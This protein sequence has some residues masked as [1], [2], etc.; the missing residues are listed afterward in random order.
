MLSDIK[1]WRNHYGERSEREV[2][3]GKKQQNKFV[4]KVKR[5][6]AVIIPLRGT[7]TAIILLDRKLMIKSNR[8]Y[9]RK[10]HKM[11]I[12]NQVLKT[13]I[14]GTFFFVVKSISTK[15]LGP[16]ISH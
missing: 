15:T 14:S 11:M 10:W 7:L 2:T 12:L 16:L 1:K 3:R 6:R 9:Q 13:Q 4:D 8:T 5:C